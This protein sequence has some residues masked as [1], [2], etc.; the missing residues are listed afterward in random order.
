ML[1]I[2]WKKNRAKL[3]LKESVKWFTITKVLNTHS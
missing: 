1:V 3:K 2:L